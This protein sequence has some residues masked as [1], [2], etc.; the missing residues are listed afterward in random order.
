MKQA[1]WGRT[2]VILAVQQADSPSEWFHLLE[3]GPV[4]NGLQRSHA[5]LH[6]K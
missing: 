5:K 6:I 2:L 4:A 1:P 3:P